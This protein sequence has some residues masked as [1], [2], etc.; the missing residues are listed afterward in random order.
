MRSGKRSIL[1]PVSPLVIPDY[2][3]Y[4][5]THFYSVLKCMDSH[6]NLMYS[7]RRFKEF[8]MWSL[9][10]LRGNLPP[11][12]FD[13]IESYIRNWGM[14]YFLASFFNQ[15]LGGHI[16]IELIERLEELYGVCFNRDLDS[17]SFFVS[18]N[19]SSLSYKLS[20]RF[21][22]IFPYKELKGSLGDLI[23]YSDL[24]L[25]IEN[26]LNGN[27][28]GIFG[29]VEGYHGNKFQSENYWG[30]KQEFCVFGIGVVDG[31][32][33]LVY[34]EESYHKGIPRVHLIFEKSHFIINDFLEVLNCLKLLFLYG[35]TAKL[36]HYDEEFSFFLTEI[37][38]MWSFPME[39]VF[40]F[41]EK[42][43][44]GGDLVGFNDG[45]IEIITSF[46]S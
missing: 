42:Y 9:S 38:K 22:D 36:Q 10:L 46:Q 14:Q 5:A 4:W 11:N 1:T 34:F 18:G 7:P 13:Q 24:C 6:K 40:R 20:N 41:L 43:I 21:T 17:F 37:K 2:K 26:S 16:I 12:F 28:V 23:G 32:Q 8:P 19:D 35:P 25:V 27:S 33:K 44:D 15:K 29:E 3:S 45:E 39:E 31:N 30:K